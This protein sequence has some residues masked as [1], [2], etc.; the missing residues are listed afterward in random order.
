MFFLDENVNF[1]KKRDHG[2]KNEYS[3]DRLWSY[4][5]DFTVYDEKF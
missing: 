4:F 1:S 5:P 2:I 3:L